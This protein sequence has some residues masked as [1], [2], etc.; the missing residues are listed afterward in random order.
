MRPLGDRAVR[1]AVRAASR[2]GG[3]AS[4]HFAIVFVSDRALAKLHARWLDDGSPTDVITFDLGDQL[5]GPAGELYVSAERAVQVARERGGSAKRE[6]A[7]YLVH[8]VLH[9]C[10]FD[11]HGVV[12][13]K[14]MRR[15]E[16]TVL[17]SLG[18]S[19][20]VVPFE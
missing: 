7:L 12:D 11:D 15:A 6:L 8:G 19:D 13:R 5:G 2:F 18:Y 3:R 14:R 4:A 16:R 9:L 1:A 10:G 17:G 20:E